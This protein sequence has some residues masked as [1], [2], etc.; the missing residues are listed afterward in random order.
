[1]V[2]HRVVSP[3]GHAPSSGRPD[4]PCSPSL[5]SSPRR[6]RGQAKRGGGRGLGGPPG[7]WRRVSCS[8]TVGND[9]DRGRRGGGVFDDQAEF[10]E[11]FEWG[12]AGV[13]RLAPGADVVVVVDVLSFTTAVDV[14]VGRGATV[15]PAR[16]GD[17]RTAGLA[18]RVGAV[19][20]GGRAAGDRVV[21]YSLAPTSLLAIPPGTRLVLPSLNGATLSLLA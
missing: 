18:A 4:S 20:A 1:M 13:R 2:R 7:V 3:D 12:E 8:A 10:R 15:F 6:T 19:L 21:P 14:A 9:R 11:R 5:R 16:W 17:A